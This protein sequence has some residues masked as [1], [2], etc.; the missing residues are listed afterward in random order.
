MEQEVVVT[1]QY[2]MSWAYLAGFLDAEGSLISDKTRKRIDIVNTNL[3]VLQTIKSFLG[4]GS[5]YCQTDYSDRKEWHS[6]CYRYACAKNTVNNPQ[7]GVDIAKSLL[8]FLIVKKQKFE[9][10][11]R[12]NIE[13]QSMSWGYVAGFFDG[14]GNITL[15][16]KAKK[17]YW[18]ITI[19]N[20]HLGVL[21]EIQKF[22]G[23]GFIHE[24]N[25]HNIKWQRTW[26]LRISGF[27]RMNDFCKAVIPY[28]IVKLPKLQEF[29]NFFDG[30]D[31]HPNYKMK[32]VTDSDFK[33]L[34]L[35]EH[36]SIRK[37]AHKYGVK[38]NPVR[39]RLLKAGVPLRGLG[40]NQCCDKPTGVHILG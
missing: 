22:I 36:L 1:N 31:W 9:D 14:E 40:T 12:L 39:E 11:F 25:H 30:H 23:Y 28:S 16:L 6:K 20:T 4:C 8:P 29:C 24:R 2:P 33:R 21:Q 19:T 38:Y 37:I 13:R 27:Y 34:Y 10:V 5:V 17:A 15:N 18:N 35:A 26:D 32:T 3:K 7:N